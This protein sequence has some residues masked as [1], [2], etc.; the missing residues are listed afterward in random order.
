MASLPG[1]ISVAGG[2]TP[3]SLGR[4]W[5]ES[6]AARLSANVTAGS[7]AFGIMGSGGHGVSWPGRP[8]YPGRRP[9]RNTTLPNAAASR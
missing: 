2:Y 8:G 1:Q 7:T 3:M 9:A 4:P 6:Q 5:L